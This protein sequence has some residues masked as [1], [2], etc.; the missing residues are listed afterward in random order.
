MIYLL[1]LGFY[2]LKFVNLQNC[3]LYKPMQITQ[4]TH[5]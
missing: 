2:A 5:C 3:I 4:N 1:F